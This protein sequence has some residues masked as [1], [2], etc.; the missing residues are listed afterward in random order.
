MLHIHDWVC[1]YHPLPDDSRAVIA[2]CSLYSQSP[3]R[4][5]P[6]MVLDSITSTR[7]STPDLTRGYKDIK[8]VL[9]TILS[10]ASA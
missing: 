5:F 6:S 2:R 1:N 3:I 8:F 9:H 7:S 4:S 10:I